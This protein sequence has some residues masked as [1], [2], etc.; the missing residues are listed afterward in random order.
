MLKQ[1]TQKVTTKK[2]RGGAVVAR[3]LRQEGVEKVFGIIDGTYFGLYGS[4]G[5]VGIDLITPRHESAAA[6]M[7]GAYAR[8]TGKLGVCL[9]SNG[10][11][12]ANIL[13]GVVTEAVEGNRVLLITSARR[14]GTINPDRGGTFQS[15]PQTEV[16]APFT[17]WSCRVPSFDRLPELVRKALRVSYSGRPGVVH[18]DVPENILNSMVVDPGNTWKPAQYRSLAASSASAAQVELAAD[19]LCK[20]KLPMI[21]AGS[22]VVHAGAF[23]ELSQVARLLHTPI[24]TSWG[25]RASVD[26]RMGYGVPL[27]YLD[28]VNAMRNKA[29]MVLCL[30]SRLGETDWWGKPPY[31]R[32]ASEQPMIQVDLDPEA[33]GNNKPADLGIVCDIKAFLTDLIKALQTRKDTIDVAPRRAFVEELQDKGAKERTRLDSKLLKNKGKGL[34]SS[35]LVSQVR[36][37]LPDNARYVFDGGNTAVWSNFFTEVRQPNT[38]FSTFKMGMLG[39]G[40]PQAIGVKVACPEAPVVCLTGDGSMGMHAQELETAVREKLSIIFCVLCDK[41]WGMVKINQSFTLRPI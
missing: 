30:G 38:I 32:K 27:I 40:T 16:T 37:A 20:A 21:H 8:A 3:M 39:A 26:E 13:S 18:L 11:G 23:E 2:I 35:E 33:I 28:Q 1:L 22:G 41:Q 5:E 29:D 4:F 7:A 17:K 36:N 19:M 12:V 31:W 10:P 24:S 25:A 14:T 6:H 15:F 9:A 34:L